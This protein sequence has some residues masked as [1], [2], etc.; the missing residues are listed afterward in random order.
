[1]RELETDAVPRPTRELLKDAVDGITNKMALLSIAAFQETRN[2]RVDTGAQI[3]VELANIKQ[4]VSRL[5]EIT[6]S[7]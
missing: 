6:G 4:A 7:L 2:N 3:S 1:M 5:K